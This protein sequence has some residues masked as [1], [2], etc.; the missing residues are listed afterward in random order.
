[1]RALE[2]ARRRSILTPTVV[3]YFTENSEWTYRCTRQVLPVPNIPTMQIF[4]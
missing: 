2:I 4:F 1:V 3:R